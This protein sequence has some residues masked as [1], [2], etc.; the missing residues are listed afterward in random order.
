VLLDHAK[1]GEGM[2]FRRKEDGKGRGGKRCSEVI[3]KKARGAEE[4]GMS[5]RGEKRAGVDSGVFSLH[6]GRKGLTEGGKGRCISTGGTLPWSRPHILGKELLF[7]S[8]LGG[9]RARRA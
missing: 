8:N 1:G 9:G 7:G 2:R 3:E 5:R 4:R 6:E